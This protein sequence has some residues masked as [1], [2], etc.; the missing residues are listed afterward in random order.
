M[1]KNFEKKA[2]TF[3]FF[4]AFSD[5]FFISRLVDDFFWSYRQIFFSPQT[6]IGFYVKKHATLWNNRLVL[7]KK[8]EGK[9]TLHFYEYN[10]TQRQC[11]YNFS[12]FFFH[13]RNINFIVA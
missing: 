6:S 10:K 8:K 11:S 7:S 12:T 5:F 9:G 1:L 4:F 13:R 2:L 3:V